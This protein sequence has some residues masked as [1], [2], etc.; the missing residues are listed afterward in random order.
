MANPTTNYGWQMPT[1]TD[2]VTD[3]PADFGVF[4]QAVDSTVFAN[5]AAALSATIVDAKGDIIAATGADAFSRLAVGANNT[6]LTADSTTATGL[7]WAAAASGGLTLLSTTSMTTIATTVSSISQAYK[8]LFIIARGID[9]TNANTTLAV[10]LNSTAN[11][12]G[13]RLE[14]RNATLVTGA[15]NASAITDTAYN[16]AGGGS[17]PTKNVHTVY[18]PNYASTTHHKVVQCQEELFTSGGEETSVFYVGKLTSISAITSITYTWASG[19]NYAGTIE[20]YG[21]N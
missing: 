13:I 5:A 18:L 8:Y 19:T 16:Y 2:L 3:L 14:A 12:Q 6:V 21:G 20:V 11:F 15:L 7:K 10:T 9:S 1:P 17:N 4:G